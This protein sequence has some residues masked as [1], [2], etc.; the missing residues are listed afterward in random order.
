MKF[1]PVVLLLLAPVAAQA[2][3]ILPPL[4][5]L[6]L[7]DLQTFFHGEPA[8]PPKAR[9]PKATPNVATAPGVAADR[10]IEDFLRAF[11]NAIKAREGS[12]ML[13]RLADNFSMGEM[14][15][16]LK[17]P[18]MF[19]MGIEHISAPT[20]LVV[21]SLEKKDATRVAKIEFRYPSQTKTKSLIFD[22]DG[23]LLTTDL[24]A[25]KLQPHG[26]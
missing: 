7:A 1:L 12:P 10:Q 15:E 24:F 20:D 5:R 22:A 16:G 14:P 3:P 25:V 6:P 26:V 23:K 11:A 18:A 4:A 9:Q 8:A 19:V 17:A 21:V 13:P 2:I